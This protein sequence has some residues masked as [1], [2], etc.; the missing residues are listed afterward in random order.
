MTLNEKFRTM[1]APRGF[2]SRQGK[3]MK[4][5][6]ATALGV[7]ILGGI[8]T[9]LFLQVGTLLI[10]AAFVAWASY[11]AVGGDN[12][13]IKLNIGSN[14]FGVFVAWLVGLL[15]LA[16]PFAGLATPIWA[17]GLV[18]I[19]VVLYI[20]ASKIPLFSSVPAVTLG[21]A[22]TFAY[23]GQTPDAFTY[24]AMLSPSFSNALVVVTVS[25]FIGTLFATA[26]AKLSTLFAAEEPA[27]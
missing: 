13:A 27:S 8:A 17:G 26:S 10:W 20:M 7:G 9:A 21:Y 11:F 12:A 5:P 6:L 24:K 23:L 4:Q 3:T 22:T 16:N 15:I 25:M 19:S 14:T 2:L 18:L 1:M